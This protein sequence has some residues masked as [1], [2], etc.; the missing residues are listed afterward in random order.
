MEAFLPRLRRSRINSFV[1]QHSTKSILV[2]AT[3]GQNPHLSWQLILPS[4]PNVS[5]TLFGDLAEVPSGL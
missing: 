4:S 3:L 2:L 5:A 1:Y